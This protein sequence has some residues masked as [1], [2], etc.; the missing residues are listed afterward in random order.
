MN[1]SEFGTELGK[2][3]E[4]AIA[5]GVM[6]RKMS[7]EEL[8]GCLELQKLEASRHFQDMARAAA[9]TIQIPRMG[10]RLPPPPGS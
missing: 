6:K 2:L 9:N 10:G 7:V 8:V 3:V 4:R 5:T 1:A